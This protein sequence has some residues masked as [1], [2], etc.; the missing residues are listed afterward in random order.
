MEGTTT[1]PPIEEAPKKISMKMLAI[2]VVIIV[3]VA[4]I[5]GAFFLMGGEEEDK[6]TASL[7]INK[8]VATTGE[9]LSFDA[10]ESSASGTINNY[11]W[12]FGDGT[13]KYTTIATTTHTYDK[14]GKYLVLLTIK[15]DKDNSDS[16]WEDIA[17]I[18]VSAP[19]Q[20]APIR[21]AANS[22]APFVVVASDNDAVISGTL[23]SFDGSASSAWAFIANK[24]ALKPEYISNLTWDFGDGSAIV[25]GSII[26][27]GAVNHTYTG[28]GVLYTAKLTAVSA[29]G[30]NPTGD[31][32]VTI[33]IYPSSFSQSSNVINPDTFV[34]VTIGDPRSLDPAFCYDTAGGEVVQAT[35]ETLIYYDGASAS[36][37]KP[38]LATEVPTV[39]NGGI[40]ADGLTY[41]FHIRSGV[42]FH[43]G[44]VMTPEDVAY[45][46][47]RVL[48]INSPAG[49]AWMIGQVL[50]PNY[51]SYGAIPTNLINDSVTYDNT[52]MTV[53]F[54][55]TQPYPGFIYCLAFTVGSVTEKAYVEEFAPEDV[56]NTRN[57]W[58]DRHVMGTGPFKMVKWASK[59][60]IQMDRF[61][62]YWQGPA[63][64]KHVLIK[65][66]NSEATREMLLL[67]GD[68]DSVY[69]D[70]Q[71]RNDVRGVDGLRIVEGNPTFN[72]D[73]IGLCQ[74]IQT[75]P[76]IEIGDIPTTFFS[77][78]HVRNAFVYAFDYERYTMDIMQN[79]SVQ[80][81]GVI[82]IGMFGY[83]PS[84]PKYV[85]DQ[86]K[87]IDELRNSSDTR[88]ADTTDSYWDNGFEI[89]LYYNTGNNARRDGCMM[90][91]ETLENASNPS[92]PIVVNVNEMEWSAFLDANDAGELPMLYIGW[93]PDYADPDDYVLPFLYS[94]GL[95]GGPLGL[96]DPVLDGMIINASMELNTTLRA[97]MYSD[98]SMYCY[99]QA[100]YL[101]TSQATS[102]HVE[103][104]WVG[105]YYFN[106]MY[107]GFGSLYYQF[108]K[109]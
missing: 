80:P 78:V 106:P 69:I 91:K 90:I 39:E 46:I 84:V 86:Q 103:R 31:Y 88:T 2:V 45:S 77:D 99:E 29:Y 72:V 35:Y 102:F 48:V 30:T 40:S 81:N 62:L 13:V 53:T 18:D 89:D 92:N 73:F 63:P 104:E 1:R 79:T 76:A 107:S 54:H 15:D 12:Q 42:K 21:D 26:A 56:Y 19:D 41:T 67:S 59:Q 66:I 52:N 109:G 34:S 28:D 70:P 22:T 75:N 94:N 85:Y 5:F 43:D 49:P 98:I 37:L 101:W 4:A 8:S 50:I 65:E 9:A 83:D 16:N 33:G 51:Y 3:V 25:T 96:N 64:L 20:A 23:V 108:T 11:T 27:K 97:A 74:D 55:L 87:V 14:P 32:L 58:M 57:S 47:Q 100:L 95:Y 17:S 6:A 71:F 105:G 24:V 44:N 93:A 10:S 7:T 36:A 61:D 38:V 68:A 60:Y 82:P